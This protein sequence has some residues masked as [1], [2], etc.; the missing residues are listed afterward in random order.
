MTITS[1]PRYAP[2][3]VPNRGSRAVVVGAGIAG[4]LAS[5][6]AA[7][8]FDSVIVVERDP[9]PEKPVARCGVPQG[10]HVHLLQTAGQHTIEDMLPGFGERLLSTGGL[11][12]DTLSD[13]VHYEKG[14][15]LTDGPRRLPMY[16]GTRPLIEWTVRRCVSE[17]EC[18]EIRPK[19]QHTGYLTDD[20]ETTVRGIRL[21][22]P[23]GGQTELGADLVVDATGRTSHTAAWLSDHGY[24][25][26]PVQEVMI[27]LAYST[28]AIDRPSGDRRTFFVPPD[29]PRTRGAAMLPVEKGQW[30]V[31][32]V[33]VHGDHPP[34]DPRDF[35]AF[36]SG[37]PLPQLSQLLEKRSWISDAGTLYPF[38]SSLRRRFDQLKQF[39]DGLV[40]VGD[41]VASFNPIYG[42]G[43]SAAALE[44]LALHHTLAEDPDG[45]LAARCFDRMKNLVDIPWKI[46]VGGDFEFP[47]TTGPK[48][49]GTDLFNQYM[50]HLFRAA[51]TDGELREK[52][53]RVLMIE[54]PPNSLLRPI[55]ICRVL[56]GTIRSASQR[57]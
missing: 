23:R 14:G 29:H 5:R 4:L 31:T 41:A 9:L 11:V 12:V 32:L 55:N 27:D 43:M 13:L 24:P 19:C 35:I 18:I 37:L 34:T 7:D 42:Q 25:H 44:A 21:R 3:R 6:V 48:P 1:V 20:D 17:I 16:C 45:T 47:Q 8:A 33:G 40:V 2:D 28:V 56:T 53:N 10:G 54:S 38:P 50:R 46:A 15:V 52:L 39:P 22:A 57:L 51:H 26:P 36:A 30:L 49:R